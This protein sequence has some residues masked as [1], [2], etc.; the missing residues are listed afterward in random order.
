[1]CDGYYGEPRRTRFELRVITKDDGLFYIYMVTIY[2][3]D[4][5]E[6]E[7][8]PFAQPLTIPKAS[9]EELKQYLKDQLDA[10][11]K[12]VVNNAIFPKE[13]V[14]QRSYFN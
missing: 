11:E 1:M 7:I 3:D 12:P 8:F 6:K 10:C 9:L 13:T 14:V 5:E 2:E 4:K